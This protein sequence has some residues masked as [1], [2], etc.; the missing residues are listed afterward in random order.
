MIPCVQDFPLCACGSKHHQ[1]L[2]KTKICF[3]NF[4][5]LLLR[6]PECYGYE[7][8]VKLNSHKKLVYSLNSV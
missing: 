4:N 5:I 6:L 1:A 2:D 7:S 3:I 8:K